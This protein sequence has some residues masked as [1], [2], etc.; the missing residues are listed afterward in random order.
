MASGG[1]AEFLTKHGLR[2][3]T[4]E[5]FAGITEQLDGGKKSVEYSFSTAT[6]KSI[7]PTSAK[8]AGKGTAAEVG[9]VPE[10]A[11]SQALVSKESADTV[12]AFEPGTTNEVPDSGSKRSK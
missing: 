9:G 10:T 11:S 4:V 8:E 2:V 12:P 6:R 3:K 7:P 5:A 1:T